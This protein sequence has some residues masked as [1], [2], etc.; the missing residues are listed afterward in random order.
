MHYVQ[1]PPKTLLIIIQN[2]IWSYCD[3]DKKLV[4]MT[5]PSKL[6]TEPH[7]QIVRADL[8]KFFVLNHHFKN[9]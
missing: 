4:S 7:L 9:L 6:K 2:S 3:S 8:L 5:W 1:C